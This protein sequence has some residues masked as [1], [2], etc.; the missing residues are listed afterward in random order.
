MLI[1]P[2][3]F[4]PP[5]LRLSLSHCPPALSGELYKIDITVFNDWSSEAKD[6]KIEPKVE[7]Q[8][9]TKSFFVF[10]KEWNVPSS[11]R[12]HLTEL[13][14]YTP[15]VTTIAPHTSI[16]KV[17]YAKGGKGVTIT[18][19]ETAKRITFD[20]S[21]TFSVKFLPYDLGQDGYHLFHF[22]L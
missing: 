6:V 8:T 20:V 3:R 13:L 17:I 5:P 4:A 2:L 15:L 11:D 1:I 9:D 14:P 16:H 21:N 19:N 12:Y 10:D 7:E 18:A 22:F